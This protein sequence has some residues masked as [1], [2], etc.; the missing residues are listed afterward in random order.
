MV[1][2]YN[3]CFDVYAEHALESNWAVEEEGALE[4]YTSNH[5]IL[6]VAIYLEMMSKHLF[7]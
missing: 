2:E 4:T 3:L 1:D 5:L 6:Y 7:S